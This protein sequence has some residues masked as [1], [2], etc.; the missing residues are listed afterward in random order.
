MTPILLGDDM[1]EQEL[2]DTAAE[3]RELRET[4]IRE[5][6]DLLYGNPWYPGESDSSYGPLS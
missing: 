3:A 5:I 4:E 1:G 2:I 6:M